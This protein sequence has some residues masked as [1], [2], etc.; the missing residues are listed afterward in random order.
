MRKNEDIILRKIHGSCFLIDI[1]DNYKG[2]K[3]P[4]FE[5]N[6]TGEFIW[7]CIVGNKEVDEL[8]KSLKE[9]IIDEVDYE[10]IFNDVKDFTD[11]LIVKGF[12]EV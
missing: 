1:T 10:L 11:E 3:C 9:A 12:L 2:D 5:I 4:I 6:E 7:N 8:A